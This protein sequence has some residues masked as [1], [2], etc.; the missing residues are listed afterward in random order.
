MGSMTQ[1][2]KTDIRKQVDKKDVQDI[3]KITDGNV[4]EDYLQKESILLLF[5]GESIHDL[6]GQFILTLNIPA[7]SPAVEGFLQVRSARMIRGQTQFTV[8]MD[9][10]TNVAITGQWSYSRH[11]DIRKVSRP[12]FDDP[13]SLIEGE[14]FH[15]TP[16]TPQ[17]STPRVTSANT[18]WTVAEFNLENDLLEH[19]LSI[20]RCE[21]LLEVFDKKFSREKK[22]FLRWSKPLIHL[23]TIEAIASEVEMQRLSDGETFNI[24]LMLA[25][26]ELTRNK[27][28]Q[29]LIEHPLTLVNIDGIKQA[30]TIGCSISRQ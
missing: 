11:P 14:I 17:P 1:R 12:M 30:G 20:D 13:N 27:R 24:T 4:M 21:E 9:I 28:V 8:Q 23:Q 10:R 6:F 3:V 22:H 16:L 5:P 19:S 26:Q 7:P 15:Q 2:V 29:P 18:K 25:E